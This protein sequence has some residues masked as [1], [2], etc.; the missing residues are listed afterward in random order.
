MAQKIR[1]CRIDFDLIVPVPLSKER[2]LER[3]YNQTMLL[4]KG[5][6]KLFDVKCCDILIRTKTTKPFHNLSKIQR[7]KEIKDTIKVKRRYADNIKGK[8]ILL[9]DD[10][11]TTGVT[12]NQC[13]MVLKKA[14]AK[15]V[16]VCVLAITRFK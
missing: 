16:Y 15:E 14:G 1:E 6:S 9:I 2:F 12:S 4:S 13:S 7:R 5:I 10:I 8:R 3:G 11:L